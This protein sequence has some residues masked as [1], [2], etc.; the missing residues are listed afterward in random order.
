MAQPFIE[1][2]GNK[3][4]LWIAREWQDY[5]ERLAE[6]AMERLVN[7]RDV[8]SQYTLSRG[9]VRVVM[10]PIKER[11]ASGTAMVTIQ[12]FQRHFARR[13]VSDLTGIDSISDTAT[14]KWF[15]L[16]VDLH[17]ENLPNAD[18]IARSN[19][20]AVTAWAG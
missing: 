17:D 8:W 3:R 1:F 9:E 5:S 10:L 7:R 12:K 15:A 13:S 20:D 6:W 14:T 18:E 16:D 19:L 2:A 11:R 4:L